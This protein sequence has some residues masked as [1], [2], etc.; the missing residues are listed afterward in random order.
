MSDF[1]R[2]YDLELRLGERRRDADRGG[3]RGD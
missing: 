1:L 2:I 3:G